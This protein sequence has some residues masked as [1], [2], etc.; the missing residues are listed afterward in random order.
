MTPADTVENYHS[1][2]SETEQHRAMYFTSS[3]TKIS[4]YSNTV[5]LGC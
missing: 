2:I 5:W 3:S 1:I 4:D